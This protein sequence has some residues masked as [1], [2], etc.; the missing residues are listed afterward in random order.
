MCQV[1]TANNKMDDM[2]SFE[3][4]GHGDEEDPV[5]ARSDSEC[6]NVGPRHLEECWVHVVVGESV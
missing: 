4:L 3:N 1:Y 2:N 5:C 6:G